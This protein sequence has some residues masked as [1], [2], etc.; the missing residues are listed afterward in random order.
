[1]GGHGVYLFVLCLCIYIIQ[2][3]CQKS[4][5]QINNRHWWH[6]EQCMTED[7]TDK[8]CFT[9]FTLLSLHRSPLTLLFILILLL[10]HLDVILKTEESVFLVHVYRRHV[11]KC[12]NW[13]MWLCDSQQIIASTSRSA[14]YGQQCV[15]SPLETL[16]VTSETI[17]S[18]NLLTGTKHPAFSTNHLTDIDKLN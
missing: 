6:V 18:A 1:M 11:Y 7:R 17:I 12:D 15:H 14:E 13:N 2:T 16:P 3:G 9:M 10:Q 5:H 4:R 8:E